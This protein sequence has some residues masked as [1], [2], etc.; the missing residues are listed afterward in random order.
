[1]KRTIAFFALGI[2]VA[3]F[4]AFTTRSVNEV[5][6]MAVV[7]QEQGIYIFIRSKPAA[8]YKFLGK[9]NM[10]EVVW[11]GKP[12]EMMNIAIRRAA[13]QFPEANGIIFQSENFGKVEAV[14]IEE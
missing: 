11:N 7:D 8:N 2:V 1:M 6:G 9:V 10:P 5:K 13:R 14:K 4:F 3:S 12:K